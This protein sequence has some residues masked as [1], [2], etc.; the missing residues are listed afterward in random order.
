MLRITTTS[1][2]ALMMA[3]PAVAQE[4]TYGK[5]SLDFGQLSEDSFDASATALNGAVEYSIDQFLLGA[6]VANQSFDDSFF[7]GSVTTL[8]AFAAY[9]PIDGLLFGAGLQSL[10]SDD[11]FG[12][13]SIDG[14][15]LFAQYTTTGFGGGMVYQ[16]PNTDVDDFTI[17]TFFA[18]AEPAPGVT[19]GLIA[20]SIEDIDETPYLISAEYADGPIFAR[21]YYT[22]VTD[23]DL[24][25]YGVRGGYA[26]SPML[27][28]TASLSG[29]DDYLA[30]EGS[31]VS[32]GAAYE[33][34]Q[35]ISVDGS[36][37]R[38]SIGDT[39]LTTVQVGLTYE[40][41]ARQRLDEKM[42]DAGVEDRR[43]SGIS[44]LLPELGFGGA[45]FGVFF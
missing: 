31:A 28:V 37:G 23:E 35:G 8:D 18:E 14:Y 27:D 15:E 10:S 32:V 16:V 19:I 36:L 9:K 41:G 2:L 24:A 43:A 25:A 1:A 26:I 4:I 34:A 17:T 20:D 21:A 6:Q 33:F 30:D 42:F 39:D 5:F 7:D 13:E 29:F 44:T 38:L 22:G 12:D 11:I 40:I 45:G 3:M